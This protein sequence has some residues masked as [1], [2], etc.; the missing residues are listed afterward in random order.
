MVYNLDVDGL[1]SRVTLDEE[2][3]TI[4]SFGNTHSKYKWFVFRKFANWSRDFL[5]ISRMHVLFFV[6]TG[7]HVHIVLNI[8]EYFSHQLKV[9]F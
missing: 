5:N 8:N 7:I 3:V 6:G 9:G 4:E 1:Q 2:K